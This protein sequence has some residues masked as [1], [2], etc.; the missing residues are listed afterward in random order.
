MVEIFFG[1]TCIFV[2]TFTYMGVMMKNILLVLV[3]FLLVSCQQEISQTSTELTQ[4]IITN[5]VD[6]RVPEENTFAEISENQVEA[7]E[8]LTINDLMPNPKGLNIPNLEWDPYANVYHVGWCGEA[9][10]QMA[11]L[12]HG[13]Y[14]SQKNINK[15][16]N[17]IRRDL[18]STDIEPAMIA[19]GLRF[20]RFISKGHTLEDFVAW[21]SEGVQAGLPVF[22]GMKKYPDKHSNWNLDHFVLF[23]AESEDKLTYNANTPGYG[24]V[25]ETKERLMS[26]YYGY[27]LYNRH[28]IYFG[29][30]I[31]GFKDQDLPLPKLALVTEDEKTVDLAISLDQMHIGKT[32]DLIRHTFEGQWDKKYNLSEEI[33][34]RVDV[35]DQDLWVLDKGLNRKANHYYEFKEVK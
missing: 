26:S 23:V 17:P 5:D 20:E 3:L 14:Y 16:G 35:M 32:Y 19:A 10:I 34:T 33:V 8:F 30:R 24:P 7:N 27:R 28:D 31:E 18:Y 11:C 15:F 12:Y 25:T 2:V 1:S 6:D 13:V 4:T 21:I 9:S 29:I 22:S